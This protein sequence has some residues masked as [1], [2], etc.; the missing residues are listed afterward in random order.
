MR[1]LRFEFSLGAPS[2]SSALTRRERWRREGRRDGGVPRNSTPDE[3]RRG[4]A[5][6]KLPAG[7]G[8][9]ERPP[10]SCPPPGSNPPPRRG[11]GRFGSGVLVLG[12]PPSRRRGRGVARGG[13]RRAESA[14]IITP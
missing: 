4:D 6:K 14:E 11:E 5:R 1:R 2:S 7:E 9:N 12:P 10:P 8:S 3:W 13:G